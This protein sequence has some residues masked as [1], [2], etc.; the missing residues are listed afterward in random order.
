MEASGPAARGPRRPWVR[1]AS[2]LTARDKLPLDRVPP[3]SD[4]PFS[5]S[6]LA[7]FPFHCSASALL[8][9]LFSLRPQSRSE[10]AA[11]SRILFSKI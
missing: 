7:S 10:V 11:L 2:A 1:V 6:P 4:L 9:A 5:L 8:S 3:P